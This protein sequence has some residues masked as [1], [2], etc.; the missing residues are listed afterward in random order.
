[1]RILIVFCL[2]LLSIACRSQQFI[3]KDYGDS[4]HNVDKGHLEKTFPHFGASDMKGKYFS[5]SLLIGNITLINLWFENCA[6]CIAEFKR[7]N[8]IF[9]KFQNNKFFNFITFM[10][11][12]DSRINEI[13]K[14]YSLNF[15]VIPISEEE[16]HR[17][18]FGSGFSTNIIVDK[19]GRVFFFKS[20]GAIQA[21]NASQEIDSTILPKL[22][23][24]L[25]QN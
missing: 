23:Q 16:C 5:D 18:N 2:L 10:F 8:E 1:M 15:P 22:S 4:M 14:R 7:L 13:V 20:G 21:A 6:P 3:L 9:E 19:D 24:L 11:E 17:L 25:D 12:N